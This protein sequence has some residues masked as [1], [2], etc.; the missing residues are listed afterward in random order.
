MNYRKEAYSCPLDE[1]RQHWKDY[2]NS[3]DSIDLDLCAQFTIDAIN[4]ALEG[5]GTQPTIDN[6]SSQKLP[7]LPCLGCEHKEYCSSN[8]IQVYSIICRSK[9]NWRQLQASRPEVGA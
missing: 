7:P 6:T 9:F 4:D 3:P 1:A 5:G 8:G 2:L